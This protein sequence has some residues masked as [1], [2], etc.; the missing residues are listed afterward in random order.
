MAEEEGEAE[1]QVGLRPYCSQNLTHQGSHF[2]GKPQWEGCCLLLTEIC[3]QGTVAIFHFMVTF[4]TSYFLLLVLFWGCSSQTK[5]VLTDF[6][7]LHI[8]HITLIT[9]QTS[10]TFSHSHYPELLFF[11]MTLHVVMSLSSLF[12]LMSNILLPVTLICSVFSLQPSAYNCN[13]DL[14]W[15]PT[16][17]PSLPFFQLH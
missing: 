11:C 3:R 6:L 7:F 1:D 8:T 2:C 17:S 4:G 5:Q 16:L 12:L 15:F 13:P 10:P 14:F 9:Y